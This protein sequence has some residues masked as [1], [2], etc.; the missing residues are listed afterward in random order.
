MLCG[1]CQRPKKRKRIHRGTEEDEEET[2]AAKNAI[3]TL[4]PTAYQIVGDKEVSTRA[5]EEDREG[6][7]KRGRRGNGEELTTRRHL[8]RRRIPLLTTGGA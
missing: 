1:Q 6:E 5:S 3:W 7:E 8:S 2:Y 4:P